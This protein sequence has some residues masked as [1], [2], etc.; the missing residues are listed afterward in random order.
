MLSQSTKWSTCSF[1]CERLSWTSSL[2]KSTRYSRTAISRGRARKLSGLRL[3]R[4]FTSRTRIRM[5][6]IWPTKLADM[7]RWQSMSTEPSFCS[8]R[9]RST[10]ISCT[11][12]LRVP[13]IS[14]ELQLSQPFT[15][16]RTPTPTISKYWSISNTRW[17]SRRARWWQLL[18]LMKCSAL[19]T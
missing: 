7:R 15:L 6:E 8:A 12:L 10:T 3:W 4:P 18:T 19:L 11:M 14:H 16:W 17:D 13:F 9:Q 2:R 1:S 5:I